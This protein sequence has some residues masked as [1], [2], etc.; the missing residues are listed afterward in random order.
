MFAVE[1]APRDRRVH[2]RDGI[3]RC[4]GPVR[5]EREPG[6]RVEQRAKGVGRLDADGADALL[7]PATVINGMVR[8]HRRDHAELAEQ[9]NILGAEVLRVLDAE[10]AIAWPMC[11]RHAVVDG[12]QDRVGAVADRVDRDLQSRGVGIADPATHVLLGVLH[13]AA[14][15]RGIA[16]G[17]DEV[18]GAGPGRT[19]DV[20]LESGDLHP[21]VPGRGVAHGLGDGTPGVER[22]VESGTQREPSRALKPAVAHEADM[23]AV[24]VTPSEAAKASARAS[25]ESRCSGDG[26]G[27]ARP[28]AS[29]ARSLKIPSGSPVLASRRISP[30]GGV[31]VSF[32]T[33]AARMAAALASA[34]WPSR[35]LRKAGLF[36]V[37]ESIHSWRGS[38]WPRHKVWSQS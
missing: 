6:P 33:P 34:S 21:V 2:P 31:G 4:D 17:L 7:H 19:I 11:A 20:S 36:G 23:C 12:Q 18:R 9:R 14:V 8:L 26:S 38:G 28:T 13:E 25:A 32:V 35:R 22:Q 30:P 3:E 16:V 24:A 29:R 37:T 10:A 27:I 1:G 5:A 15:A